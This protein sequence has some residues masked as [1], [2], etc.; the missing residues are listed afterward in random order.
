MVTTVG[1]S[2]GGREPSAHH[3][4]PRQSRA[5]HR[6]NILHQHSRRSGQQP[7]AGNISELGASLTAKRPTHQYW[8][9]SL[10]T[11]HIH[12]PL[13]EPSAQ[14][15]RWG[16]I[17]MYSRCTWHRC[18]HA[19]PNLSLLPQS[20]AVAVRCPS[21]TATIICARQQKS[22]ALPPDLPLL[23]QRD[24]RKGKERQAED[25]SPESTEG[26]LDDSQKGLSLRAA[27]EGDL[28]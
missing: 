7:A 13:G 17:P 23:S 25:A 21:L 22:I 2:D 24:S 15:S 11:T 14:R 4:P 1:P 16:R 9:R 26:R 8:R 6:T 27:A 20:G 5:D 28:E 19:R 10:P 3:H 12:P 18:A